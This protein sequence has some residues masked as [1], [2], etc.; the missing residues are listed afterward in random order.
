MIP[1]DL[2]ELAKLTGRINDPVIRNLFAA[3]SI[4]PDRSLEQMVREMLIAEA[5]EQ[6]FDPQPFQPIPGK[7]LVI[8]GTE[9]IPYIELGDVVSLN[10]LEFV[11]KNRFR[12]PLLSTHSIF[13]G[14][15]RSGKTCSVSLLLRQLPEETKCWIFDVGEDL[16]YFNLALSFPAEDFY[17]INAR[18]FKRN[19]F[20]PPPT[21]SHEEWFNHCKPNFRES[22]FLRD[23]SIAM[24]SA[25]FDHCLKETKEITLHHIYAKLISMKT[26]LL[27]GG[28]EYQYY[29]S[30]KNRFESLLL[31]PM[32]DC[33]R[34]FD[35]AHLTSKRVLWLCRDLSDEEYPLFVNDL[36]TW[37]GCYFSH[38][39]NP[40]P[41]LVVVIEELHR[42]TS[43]QR[44]KRAD[45]TEPIILKAVRELAKRRIALMFVDQ[46][47]SELPTQIMANANFRAIFNTIEGRDLDALQ[48]S[49]SL[50]YE[51]RKFLSR[52]PRQVCV[53]KYAN[54]LFPEPFLVLTDQL[55]LKDEY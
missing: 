26:S 33:V 4:E 20:E 48:R 45:L 19:I 44:L 29:E 41:R 55:D 17:I 27:K 11:K 49:L 21:C 24:L 34:G 31:N 39:F 32:Y 36:L 53:I 30:L 25:I 14:T 47:P 10:S 46:V 16:V 38:E 40:I 13:S 43:P 52:L 18:D 9:R 37:L 12:F 5:G 2:I 15:T 7:A 3:L 1:D 28:R 42:L 6:S 22:F 54:H 8:P 23:G 50:S 51:Q 35:L